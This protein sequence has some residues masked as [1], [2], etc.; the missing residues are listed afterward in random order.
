VTLAHCVECV[1]GPWLTP[2]APTS[3]ASTCRATTSLLLVVGSP[4]GP[5]CLHA[6]RGQ[7]RE[8]QARVIL[9]APGSHLQA[10]LALGRP[11]PDQRHHSTPHWHR[12]PPRR[13]R[14]SRYASTL[15]RSNRYLHL[16]KTAAKPMSGPERARTIGAVRAVIQMSSRIGRGPWGPWGCSPAKQLNAETVC[17]CWRPIRTSYQSQWGSGNCGAGAGAK[18]RP[19]G[20][21]QWHTGVRTCW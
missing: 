14:R 20:Q 18:N 17:C 3:Q 9:L 21:M 1:P 4:T 8:H 5:T 15:A 10:R 16:P 6:R 11:L 13:A 2:S 7:R 19:T 12:E